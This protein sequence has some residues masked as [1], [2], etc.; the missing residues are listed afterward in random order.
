MVGRQ[1]RSPVNIDGSVLRRGVSNTGAAGG[2]SSSLCLMLIVG[3]VV[4][5]LSREWDCARCCYVICAN[6]SDEIEVR[7]AVV[8]LSVNPI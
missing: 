8:D 3:A 5:S 1:S 7:D 2:T 4:I 6:L